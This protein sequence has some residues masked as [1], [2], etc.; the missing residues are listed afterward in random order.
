M[1]TIIGAYTHSADR[2]NERGWLRTFQCKL[3]GSECPLLKRGECIHV[4]FFA[5]CVYGD[6]TEQR[7]SLKRSRAYSG[8]MD[9]LRELLKDLP[10]MPQPASDCGIIAIG[11]YYYIPYAHAAMCER[12][13]FVTHSSLFVSGMPFVKREAFGPEQVVT[14]VQFRP[15]ALM[16]GE[17]TAYQM[18]VPTFLYHLKVRF[19]ELYEAAAELL[20]EVRT[21]TLVVAGITSLR[22][23]LDAIPVGCTDGFKVKVLGSWA[24]VTDHRP[25]S[26]TIKSTARDMGLVLTV[27][28]AGEEATLTYCPDRKRTEVLV[29]DPDLIGAAIAADPSL[30]SK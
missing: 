12:V 10:A 25:E 5:R 9:R 7:T 22:C 1:A 19:P 28:T 17:I 3:E 30:M 24:D 6:C 29:T 16:G 27:K 11:D 18:S 21:R 23:H 15:H 13:P 26:I 2:G 14:L 20:P 4:G 8:E